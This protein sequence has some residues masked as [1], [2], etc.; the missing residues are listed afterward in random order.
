MN[1]G[2]LSQD[3]TQI[4]AAPC[5]QGIQQLNLFTVVARGCPL[6]P[7]APLDV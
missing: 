4:Y 3:W 7:H 2:E 5:R 1:I 6:R